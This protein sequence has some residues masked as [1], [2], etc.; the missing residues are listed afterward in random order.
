[1]L[2]ILL[3]LQQLYSL[4][5]PEML[6]HLIS[7]L[8]IHNILVLFRNRELVGLVLDRDEVY[9]VNQDMLPLYRLF[10]HLGIQWRAQ[11]YR[12]QVSVVVHTLI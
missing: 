3:L 6:E 9:V 8:C 11:G 12:V 2:G 7:V 5:M 10:D 4:P 1:M